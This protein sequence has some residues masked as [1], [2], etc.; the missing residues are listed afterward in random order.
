MQEFD[1]IYSDNPDDSE[2]RN[3]KFGSKLFSVLVFGVIAILGSTFA[4]NINLN[5]GQRV[6]FGQG[7]TQM[8]ACDDEITLTPV[9]TFINEEGGGAHYFSALKVSGIDSSSD[10]CS[11]KNFEFWAYSDV[12]TVPLF[13]FEDSAVVSD[14][15]GTYFTINIT[16]D[17]GEFTWI[18]GGTGGDDVIQG[19]VV[20]ITNTSFTLSL[21]GSLGTITRRPLALAEDV[22]RITLESKVISSWYRVDW[23]DQG[24]TTPSSGGSSTYEAGFKVAKIPT[25]SPLKNGFI[26]GGWWTGPGGSGTQIENDNDYRP[27]PPRYITFYAK[28]IED[29]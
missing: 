7:V 14:E 1:D 2:R 6:E 28:W 23:N 12:G 29:A 26:F 4:A 18:S 22:K 17:A 15:E 5:S 13:Y 11:G 20:D 24:A 9:S 27:N 21:S 8:V 16:N 25:I 19:P 10:K 3:P